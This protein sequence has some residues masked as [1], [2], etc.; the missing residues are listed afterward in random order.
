MTYKFNINPFYLQF[1]STTTM[2]QVE[3]NITGTFEKQY[4][5]VFLN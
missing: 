1:V 4:F 3:W 2:E 5:L